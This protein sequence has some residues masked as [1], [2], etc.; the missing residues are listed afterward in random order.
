MEY[1]FIILLSYLIGNI[2]P[3]IIVSRRL[4][5]I[6]IRDI[7]SKNAGTSNVT[8]S[9]GARWGIVVLVSDILK[10]L[11]PVLIVR[12]IYPNNDILWFLSGLSVIMGHIFP[13]YHGFKGGKGTATFG[14]VL[15]A[16]M[17]FYAFIMFFIFIA[18]LYLTDYIALS[19]LVAVVVTPFVMYFYDYSAISILFMS[20]FAF[21]SFYKHLENFKRIVRK[22]ELGISKM[23]EYKE[24]LRSFNQKK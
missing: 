15:F 6:D 14:G 19:T 2:N 4:K 7:N 20:L 16:T 11:I 23:G 10:G 18:V 1:V 21:I 12:I 5:G 24:K 3:A 22:K 17:P 13:Y 9:F 8:M